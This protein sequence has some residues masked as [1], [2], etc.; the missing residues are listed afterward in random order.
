MAA[1]LGSIAVFP[2]SGTSLAEEQFKILFVRGCSFSQVTKQ[3]LRFR[4]GW[5][6]L[7]YVRC[8][9]VVSLEFY[10]EIDETLRLLP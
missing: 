10:K 4:S 6:T 3:R 2:S 1:D 8:Y 7:A 5:D 9:I